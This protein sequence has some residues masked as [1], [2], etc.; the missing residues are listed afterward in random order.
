MKWWLTDVENAIHK[1]SDKIA[2]VADSVAQELKVGKNDDLFIV[3]GFVRDNVLAALSGKENMSKDIDLI[4]P[5]RPDLENNK[6]IVKKRLNSMGG[7]KIGTKNFPEIDIFQHNTTNVQLV[8]G[9]YFDFNCNALYYSHYS[10]SIFAT[11]YFY[12]FISRK[13]LDLLNFII[14]PNSTEQKYFGHSIVSRALKFQVQFQE[15]YGM[16]VNLS[17]G[18]LGLLYSMDKDTEQKMFE[19]TKAKVKNQMLQ[20]KIISK[21]K[22]LK[23]H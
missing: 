21:Y 8:I 11:S 9:E 7:L 13:T 3:G 19:Y 5:K 23:Q 20:N 18:I 2:T 17:S 6:N 22:Q 14:I 4:L 15:K 12:D 16:R 1:A 10:K